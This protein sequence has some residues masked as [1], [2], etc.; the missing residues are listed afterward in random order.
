MRLRPCLLFALCLFGLAV[1][2]R[3]GSVADD[4]DAERPV[5]PYPHPVITEVFFNV[6]QPDEDSEYDANGDGERDAR[7]DEFVELHNPHSKSIDLEGYTLVSRLAWRDMKGKN[8]GTKGVRFTFPKFKLKPGYAVV[9]FNTQ[10]D[11]LRGPCG[12]EEAGPRRGH[13]GFDG[14]F[15]FGVSSGSRNRA[16][17]NSGDFVLLLT[18]NNQPLECVHWGKLD[19]EPPVEKE[20]A[21]G[22]DDVE[23]SVRT[24][25]R[26][27]EVSHTVVGSVARSPW[28]EYF[29]HHGELNG[30]PFSPGIVETESGLLDGSAEEND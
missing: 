6:P 21:R 14:A 17:R 25:Y 12:S 30:E 4:G 22:G 8:R 7:T 13:P 10:A 3:G 5:L 26:M 16:F 24:I 18:P 20:V 23:E 15:V 28:G 19:V 2:V 1:S 27:R 29:V 9:V 11:A